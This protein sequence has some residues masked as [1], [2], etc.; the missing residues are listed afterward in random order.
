MNESANQ[1]RLDMTWLHLAT[2]HQG[3][4]LGRESINGGN[5]HIK[6]FYYL[7]VDA[8]SGKLVAGGYVP[9][10]ALMDTGNHNGG[11]SGTGR[12]DAR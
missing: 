2:D 5:T 8:A 6:Y 3:N 1:K 10:F 9:P 4:P 12:I 11:G 7:S